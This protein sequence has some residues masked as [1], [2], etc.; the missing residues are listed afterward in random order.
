MP[1]KSSAELSIVSYA[2]PSPR[3]APPAD[4][5]DGSLERLI[6]QEVIT[7]AAHDHFDASDRPLLAEYCRSAAIAR[8]A[9]EE[10][11]VTAVAGGQPSPWLAV[12]VAAVR[13]MTSL[14]VRLRLGPKSRTPSQR[15]TK[16][17][18]EP[19]YYDSVD[20]RDHA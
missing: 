13:S 19:S 1:R 5:T 16:R 4:F 12:H 18:P 11:A 7:G 14:A 17:G 3:L 15:A 9:A 6:W 10:L 2:Q 8:R 20:D